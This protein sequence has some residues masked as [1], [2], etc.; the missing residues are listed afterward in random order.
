MA[1]ISSIPKAGWLFVSLFLQ[2]SRENEGQNEE[3]TNVLQVYR[4]ISITET[5][6]RVIVLYHKDSETHWQNIQKLC[7]CLRNDGFSV[8][9]F[10][11]DMWRNWR[12]FAEEYFVNVI[13]I[14]SKKLRTLCLLYKKRKSINQHGIQTWHKLLSERQGEYVPCIVLDKLRQ[15][16]QST[17]HLSKI[18]VVTFDMKNHFETNVFFKRHKNILLL[19][20][21]QSYFISSHDLNAA[22]KTSQ[23]TSQSKSYNVVFNLIN[24][25]LETYTWLFA[26]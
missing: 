22:F 12:D 20:N 2:E 13:F 21:A 3:E 23:S 9:G 11:P 6:R 15:S 16:Y 8:H 26:L 1:L 5:R 4:R 17:D 24:K 7:N 25:M 19:T 14:S 10:F 18:H